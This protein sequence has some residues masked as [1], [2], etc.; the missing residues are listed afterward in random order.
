G[1]C[2]ESADRWGWGLVNINVRAY[3]TEGAKPYGFEVAEQLGWRLPRHIG[4]PVAGGTILP[5]IAKGFR[6]LRDLGLVDGDFK[7]Y[8]AQA[9][10]CAPVVQA[11]HK[12]TDLISPVKP[13]TIAKS[14]AIGNPADGFYLLKAVRESGGLGEAVTDE[15]VGEAS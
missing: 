9:G 7:I 5:K 12:H 15:E 4:V 10:G 1:V 13:A 3:Y 11:L 14:I 2:G 8:G 6:E